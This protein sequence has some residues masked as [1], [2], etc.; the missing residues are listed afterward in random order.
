MELPTVRRALCAVLLLGHI[1]VTGAYAGGVDTDVEDHATNSGQICGSEW[2]N[3]IDHRQLLENTALHAP[4]VYR[5]MVA[6]QKYRGA[7]RM[8]ALAAADTWEFF[9]INQGSGQYSLVSATKVWEGASASVWVDNIDRNHAGWNAAIM[10]VLP[11]MVKA[12]DSATSVSS[13]KPGQGIMKNDVDVFGP[14]PT[15]FAEKM[16]GKTVLLLTDIQDNLD[17]GFVGGYFSP[18][19]Q[20]NELGSNQMNLLTLDSHDGI[21]SGIRAVNSTIAHEF[22]HLIHYGQ[23]QFSEIMYNEGLSETASIVN[24]YRDRTNTGFLNKT[25]VDMFRWSYE[26]GTELLTD[27]ERAMTLMYYIYEQYGEKALTELVKSKAAS[28][29]RIG[30]AVQK[31]GSSDDWMTVLKNFAVANYLQNFPT[32]PRYGYTTRLSGS[33][34]KVAKQFNSNNMPA[35]T[36]IT[37]E[38]YASSYFTYFKPSGVMKLRFTGSTFGKFAVMAI[39]YRGTDITVTDMTKNTLYE[40]GKDSLPDKVILVYVN[41]SAGPQ[42]IRTTLQI[43]IPVAGVEDDEQAATSGLSLLGNA[44]NPVTNATLLRFTTSVSA[45]VTLAV[46]DA[47]GRVI[48]TVINNERYESGEHAVPFNAD[49]LPGGWYLLRLRQEGIEVTRPLTILR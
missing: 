6:D 18:N 45:P 3:R 32:Q 21:L 15:P 46:Y 10:N 8:R 27:Y 28:V 11:Q 30:D 38:S 41:L 26:N 49:G 47:E 37:V 29:Q 14:V 16:N 36:T 13:R 9:V 1:A 48:C 17:G 20:T 34:A 39:I 4:E 7:D 33:S 43:G 12:I 42:E 5:A 40:I 24:G 19:D 22:Q 31:S 2:M 44:P 25:N 35:D 23:N